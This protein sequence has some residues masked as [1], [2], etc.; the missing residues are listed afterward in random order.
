M[1]HEIQREAEL[2]E[3]ALQTLNRYLEEDIP[4]M[5]EA[6]KQSAAERM[7]TEEIM[8]KQIGEEFKRID[9]EIEAERKAREE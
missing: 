1:R 6:I 3:Q 7:Q 8:I 4:T 9:E 5:Y 2:G